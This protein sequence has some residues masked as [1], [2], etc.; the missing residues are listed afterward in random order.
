MEG[1]YV[2]QHYEVTTLEPPG[3][4]ENQGIGIDGGAIFAPEI[5]YFVVRENN[6]VAAR[7]GRKR[8]YFARLMRWDAEPPE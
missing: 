1:R 8:Q 6:D 3:V 2:C 7:H 4:A 5:E